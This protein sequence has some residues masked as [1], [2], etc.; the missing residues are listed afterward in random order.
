M[1]DAAQLA[2]SHWNETPLFL[3]EQARYSEYPWLYDVAEFREHAGHKV[4]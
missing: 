4:L 3:T 2:E 1:P